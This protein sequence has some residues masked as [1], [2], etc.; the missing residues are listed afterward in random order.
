MP[1]KHVLYPKNLRDKNLPN[2][3]VDKVGPS[4]FPSILR[5]YSSSKPSQ[6]SLT[7]RAKEHTYIVFVPQYSGS[8]LTLVC[9]E[10]VQNSMN[11]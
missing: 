7:D 10:P 3:K 6:K 9:G 5:A 1:F 8:G 2:K 4:S 11:S